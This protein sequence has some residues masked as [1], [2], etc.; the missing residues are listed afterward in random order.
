[1][2]AHPEVRG[3]E[4]PSGVP[5]RRPAGRPRERQPLRPD[6]QSLL[7]V[8]MGRP[9][10]EGHPRRPTRRVLPHARQGQELL[11]RARRDAGARRATPW[12]AGDR[13][14]GPHPRSDAGGGG[15]ARGSVRRQTPNGSGSCLP[16]WITRSSAR[17][18]GTSLEPGCTCPVCGSPCSV[19]R[20]QS[21]KVPT[22]RSGR[23]P[24]WWRGVRRWPRISCSRSWVAR[25]G[26]RRRGGRAPDGAGDR[27]PG[28]RPGDALPTAAARPARR[29]LL[30]GR[31]RAHAVAVGVVRPRGPGGASLRDA[32]RR[33]VRRRPPD[34]RAGGGLLVEGYDAADHGDA[35]RAV[36]GD[37]ALSER[38]GAA[39]CS[40]QVL[41]FTWTPARRSARFLE[42]SWKRLHDPRGAGPL[43]AGGGARPCPDHAWQ[44]DPEVWWLMDYEGPFSMQD[45]VESEQRARAEGSSVRDRGRRDADRSDRPQR[46]PSP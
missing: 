45:I 39:E 8:R 3:P 42:S 16:A 28:G 18:I 31:C 43:A 21:H 36:L 46:L 38:L 27:S 4:V 12:R 44:N 1:M 23:S 20:L 29:L 2:P 13:R 33:R 25:V 24:R 40:L 7:V 11:A 41:A 9:R 19:G 5:G 34:R 14:S 37:P 22:W 26:S 10:R 30:G 17:R 15:P 32:G 35:V 6:P